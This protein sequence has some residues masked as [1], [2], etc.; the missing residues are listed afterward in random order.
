MEWIPHHTCGIP[1]QLMS[2]NVT[3]KQPGSFKWFIQKLSPYQ[4]LSL[5][6][7]NGGVASIWALS[8]SSI[9]F[10]HDDIC[11]GLDLPGIIAA[12][13]I[14]KNNDG[15]A[16]DVNTYAGEMTNDIYIANNAMTCLAT[17]AQKWANLCD[18]I[19]QS[20]VFHKCIVQILSFV[21]V[22]SSLK[23]D[24]ETNSP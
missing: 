14:K 8:S 16:N 12:D 4:I 22:N 5:V 21:N 7:G 3:S 11:K 19:A 23:I 2:P 24:Y 15:Y 6:Q 13:G 9:F 20:I 10:A 18:A 17:G 1:R